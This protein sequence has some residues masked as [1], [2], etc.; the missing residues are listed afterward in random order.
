MA[1]KN[2]SGLKM[3]TR[4]KI[5]RIISRVKLALSG[6]LHQPPR[7]RLVFPIQKTTMLMITM[8]LMTIRTLMLT[9][10]GTWQAFRSSSICFP[11][12]LPSSI[13]LECSCYLLFFFSLILFSSFRPCVRQHQQKKNKKKNK[14]NLRWW[15]WKK[16]ACD[17]LVFFFLW[18]LLRA[19][20]GELLS[21]KHF[22]RTNL[23]GFFP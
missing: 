16:S 21:L 10:K 17:C 8:T 23:S 1:F 3:L 14:K 4:W 7:F 15:Y 18:F 2:L 20:W 5:V 12:T 11:A 22:C 13:H 9:R 6:L 19:K